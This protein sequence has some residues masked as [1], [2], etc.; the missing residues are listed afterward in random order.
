MYYF[1]TNFKTKVF[2]NK[3]WKVKNR[4]NEP[5][6]RTIQIIQ[7]EE[8]IGKKHKQSKRSVGLHQV[9]KHIHNGSPKREKKGQREHL[10]NGQ[11]VKF[12]KRH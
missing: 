11:N 6:D 1:C 8:Q 7:S 2:E 5:K 4:I 9:Y 10:K 3:Y 12:D